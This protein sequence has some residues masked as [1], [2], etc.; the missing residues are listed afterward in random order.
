MAMRC[1]DEKGI[2]RYFIKNKLQVIKPV[3][4]GFL[5][6]IKKGFY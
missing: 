1:G 6:V 4:V 2:R 3:T 5:G